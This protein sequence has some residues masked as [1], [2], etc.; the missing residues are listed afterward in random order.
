MTTGQQIDDGGKDQPLVRRPTSKGVTPDF[1]RGEFRRESVAVTRP[2]ARGEPQHSPSAKRGKTLETKRRYLFRRR[3]TH[4]K[5]PDQKKTTEGGTRKSASERNATRIKVLVTTQS[6]EEKQLKSPNNTRPNNDH[7]A[8]H[9]PYSEQSPKTKRKSLGGGLLGCAESKG[10]NQPLLREHPTLGKK[11][12]SEN[13]FQREQIDA[14]TLT[15][16]RPDSSKRGG[17]QLLASLE[18]NHK[19]KGLKPLYLGEISG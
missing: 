12:K 5:R 10:V 16:Q 4:Y 3:K 13:R 18:K 14:K 19:V 8:S 6:K 15:H 2:P 7:H 11:V 9:C 17:P 1:G